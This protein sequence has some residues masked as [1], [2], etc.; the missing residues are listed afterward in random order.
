MAAYQQGMTPAKLGDYNAAVD[1]L[2][3]GEKKWE[4]NTGDKI[5]MMATTAALRHTAQKQHSN[6][7]ND[8]YYY[9]VYCLEET[10]EVGKDENE[11]KPSQ[12]ILP[13]KEVTTSNVNTDAI[14]GY[15]PLCQ[16]MILLLTLLVL[17]PVVERTISNI[18]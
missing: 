15:L 10:T 3:E 12:F 8:E 9:E 6:K 16:G 4:A 2:L 13:K 1:V 18:H 7:D 11:I 14:P 17:V 5:M